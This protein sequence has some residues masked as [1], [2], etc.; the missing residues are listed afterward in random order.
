MKNGIFIFLICCVTLSTNAQKEKLYTLDEK[1]NLLKKESQNYTIFKVIV[2]DDLNVFWKEVIDSLELYKTELM[3]YS[4]LAEEK[5]KVAEAA[6]QEKI[7]IEEKMNALQ[8]QIQEKTILGLKISRKTINI[9][10]WFVFLSL[11]LVIGLLIV[12]IRNIAQN[13][14]TDVDEKNRLESELSL[15][16]EKLRENKTKLKRELQ[17]ALNEIEELKKS[18]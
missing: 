7:E 3:K 4:V 15:Q 2:K 17:T 16:K 5:L 9:I 8:T 14:K 1:F 13:S 10:S 6:K 11:I 12:K 18:R